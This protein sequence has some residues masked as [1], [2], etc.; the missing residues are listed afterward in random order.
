MDCC[1]GSCWLST[2]LRLRGFEDGSRVKTR[3]DRS[4]VACRVG[5]RVGGAGARNHWQER[6]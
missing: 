6:A 4:E 1:H 3:L 5:D 2:G